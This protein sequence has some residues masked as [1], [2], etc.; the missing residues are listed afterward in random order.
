MSLLAA[1]LNDAEIAVVSGGQFVYREPG[2]ALLD[3]Q[4]LKTGREAYASFRMRPRFIQHRFWSDLQT[5]P[6][7]DQRFRHLSAADLASN[8]L[9]TIWKSAAGHGD[10]LVVAVPPY[11]S[12]DNLA[13]LLGIAAE[14]GVPIAAMVDAAVAATRREYRNA[15]PVHVDLSLHSAT[16]TRIAQAGQVQVDRSA[17][18]AEAG[19]LSLFDVWVRVIAESFVR[20]C[21]FDPLH[22]AETEQMLADR[23][24]AWLAAAAQGSSVKLELEYR[25]ITHTAEIESLELTNAAAP[26]YQGIISHLRA[27]YRA[28]ETPA[29]QLTHRAALLPGLADMLRARV[30][31]EV[32]LLEP[33]A[34]ARGLAARC[35]DIQPGSGG[36]SLL[37]QL[38][39]DQAA[40]EVAPR[41]T[42]RSG[43]QPTH[44]LFGDTAYPIGTRPLLIGTQEAAE[45]RWIDLREDMPGVSRRHCSVALENGQCI[46]RDASRYGTFL[47]G[48]PIDES[49]VLAVGDQLRVGMPGYE[50]RLIRT[51]SDGAA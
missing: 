40:V 22:T 2:F 37:R 18:V 8:Q 29:I 39:W 19:L 41:Q 10:R 30:G 4:Q 26:V 14:I 6:L 33:G 31:G 42:E 38:P 32:F 9:E 48:Q 13:L 16:L 47:N 50:F 25:G 1:D 44:L 43:R 34:A 20:E 7:P 23:I 28:D 21:R 35:R 17:V 11:M 5:Q 27:L 46:V 15:V 36:V 3:E 12:K 24:T 49:A 51:E 45:E